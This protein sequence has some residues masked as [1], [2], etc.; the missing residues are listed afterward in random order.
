MSEIADDFEFGRVGREPMYP[1]DEWF[2][3]RKHRITQGVDFTCKMSSMEVTVYKRAKVRSE[4]AK[5]HL[6][7]DSPKSFVLQVDLKEY[8]PKPRGR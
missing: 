7:K 1:W 4:I 6:K 2:D 3:G 8:N 5:V